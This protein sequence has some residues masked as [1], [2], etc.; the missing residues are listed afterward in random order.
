MTTCSS[1]STT[2][3]AL[4]GSRQRPSPAAR[5]PSSHRTSVFEF[6]KDPIQ[7]KR[8]GKG[9]RRG[10]AAYKSERTQEGEGSVHAKA[11]G[12]RACAATPSTSRRP[13]ASSAARPQKRTASDL[14]EQWYPLPR[15]SDVSCSV[16]TVQFTLI[17][18]FPISLLRGSVA[19]ATWSHRLM[20]LGGRPGR[21]TTRESVELWAHC[22]TCDRWF[23]GSRDQGAEH[24]CPVCGPP[25]TVTEQRELTRPTA[26]P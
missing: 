18:S 9:R 4:G 11:V 1:R 21:P 10:S 6:K 8:M 17:S 14:L 20:A 2:N 16:E 3:P 7:P 25:S 15:W 23:C 24:V 26:T 12:P 13:I 22:S 19:S 5:P